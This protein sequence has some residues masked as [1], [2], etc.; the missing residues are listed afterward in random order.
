MSEQQRTTCA[1]VGGG[2]AG[3]MLGLLLARAGVEVTVL[4]KHADFL[5]DFRGDTVHPSTLDLLDELGLGE[6]FARLPARHI[7]TIQLPIG[8][9]TVEVASLKELP[10]P[11]PYIAMVPQ[12]D[13]L[14]LLADAAERERTFTLRRSTAV[15]GLV[16]E[17]GRCVGVRWRSTEGEDEGELRADLVV[18]C[19]GRT[20]VVRDAAGL[21]VREW[22]VPFDAWWFR[23]PRHDDD[24]AGLLPI[25]G[26]RRA[27]IMIDRD[28]YWQIAAL[29]A[30]GSDARERQRPFADVLASLARLAPWL[31]DRVDAVIHWDDVKLLDVRLDRLR[32]WHAPGV[33]CIGDAAHAM[34]PAGGVGI[35]LAIQDAVATARI[36]AQPL[37]D[38]TLTEHDLAK[39]QRRRTVPT[40]VIQGLQR[41]IHA[42]GLAPAL[43]GDIDLTGRTT[44]PLPLRVIQRLPYLRTAPAFVIARGVLPEHAPEFARRPER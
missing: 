23:I 1:I 32:T 22:P 36:V 11:H 13:L 9:Q 27:W 21:A 3:M 35:N 18:G 5:R 39:V 17:A 20:S 37:V 31:A 8:G 33:L 29:I 12:W 30:K 14:D 2:P 43:R 15:T 19:D 28:S 4:E 42:R 25:M 24:P 44:L 34:S 10:G 16:H 26:E 40:A 38:G 41:V 7:N 6:E